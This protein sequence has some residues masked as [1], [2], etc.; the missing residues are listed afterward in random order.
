MKAAV[1]SLMASA[2]SLTNAVT[3]RNHVNGGCRGNSVQCSYILHDVCCGSISGYSDSV[4]VT[5]L[6]VYGVASL[7][8]GSG[9]DACG[10]K[11]VISNTGLDLCLT[12]PDGIEFTTGSMWHALSQCSTSCKRD[13]VSDFMEL[14]E[15]ERLRILS[16]K[17][18]K[19]SVQPDKLIL[20]DG[21]AFEIGNGTSVEDVEV[22]LEMARAKADATIDDVPEH[23]LSL[24]VDLSVL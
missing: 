14:P 23:L 5:G 8:T 15:E 19:G 13:P 16:E 2:I 12:N 17:G 22:L 24:K 1:V 7:L 11:V 10:G 20:S 3:L 4:Y 9:S 18:C 6:H 21:H